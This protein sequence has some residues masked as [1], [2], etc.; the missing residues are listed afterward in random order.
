MWRD[1]TANAVANLLESYCEVGKKV[2]DYIRLINVYFAPTNVQVQWRRHIEACIGWNLR[3]KHP[4]LKK[5]YSDDNRIDK[6]GQLH[7][8]ILSLNLPEDIAGIDKELLV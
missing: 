7:G 8:Q 2:I 3:I 4:P 5:Y 1:K 6:V